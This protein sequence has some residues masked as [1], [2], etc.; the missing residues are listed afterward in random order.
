MKQ[1]RLYILMVALIC[2]LL[3]TCKSADAPHTLLHVN[4]KLKAGSANFALNTNY[5]LQGKLVQF[6][7]VRFYVC[8]F[9]YKTPLE[10]SYTTLDS[11]YHI[12]E[13]GN[14]VWTIP[15]KNN[16][17]LDRIQFGMGVDIARND[18]SG[19]L[20]IPA[21]DYPAD[22]PLSASQNMYWSWNPGYI[23]MKLEGRIDLDGN[24]SLNDPGETFSL[25]TGLNNAF[26]I[27][28]KD[29]HIP[30]GNETEKNIYIETDIFRFFDNYDLP[31]QLNAHPTNTSHPEYVYVEELV[32]N[33]QFVFSPFY[34]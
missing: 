21:Y 7:T 26:R 28:N 24:N 14:T 32:E 31:N 23:F 22:H 10:N 16:I 2:L 33:I 18:S 1:P 17:T 13:P 8:H 20:A 27:V 12:V 30:I 34:Q 3:V 4:F 6:T 19:I 11:L 9:S 5:T 25:H 29:V 15:L